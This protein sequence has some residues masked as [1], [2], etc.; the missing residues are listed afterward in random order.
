M[1]TRTSTEVP[2]TAPARASLPTAAPARQGGA[3]PL[4][5]FEAYQGPEGLDRLSA[6]WEQLAATLPGG[7]RFFDLPHWYRPLF[8]AQGCDPQGVW[9]IAAR[10]AGV[11]VAVCPLQFQPFRVLGLRPRI[12]GTIEDDQL[13]L[14]D[15]VFAHSE[16]N[17][18][19]L[20]ALI[21]WLRSQRVLRWDALRLRKVPEDAAITFSARA[22]LPGGSLV[23]AHDGSCW[24]DVMHGYDQATRDVSKT[25]KQ[26][27]RRLTRRAEKT[28]PL[29]H[30]C[31]SDP[32]E[33]EQAFEHFLEIEASGW[34]G[35]AGN[36]GAILCQPV[37]LAF[38]RSL[39]HEFGVRGQ[40]VVN[41]LWHGD[42]AVA[43]QLC[44]RVGRVLNILKVGFREEHEAFAPGI[45]L[46]DRVI[47]QACD[48]EGID[49]L[50]L[51]NEP[52]WSRKFRP[53]RMDVWSYVVINPTLRGVAVLLG[54]L[55]KRSRDALVLRFGA[56]RP[57]SARPREAAPAASAA[58]KH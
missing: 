41:L 8:V 4:L 35:A 52:P 2:A 40:C 17:R 49:I 15:F 23:A 28:H 20:Y 11:L 56:G 37:L 6:E 42:Q 55:V 21:R 26:D 10:R 25:F 45:L 18:E 34:K 1:M 14:A 54:L 46:L 5:Q 7:P 32:G 33:V 48:D 44:L 29:R 13:Q 50:H 3:D 43:A 47:H 30:Q 16:Q 57:V 38:Y 19:L 51:V 31:C 12:L 27:F 22:R 36:A 39:V 53:L 9:F 58:P 24:L